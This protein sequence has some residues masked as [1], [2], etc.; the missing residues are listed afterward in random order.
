M[1]LIES[2]KRPLSRAVARLTISLISRRRL[3][4]VA[5][6]DHVLYRIDA[7][8]VGTAGGKNVG[9]RKNAALGFH[10][11]ANDLAR[12]AGDGA[13]EISDDDAVGRQFSLR[14]LKK[15]AGRQM[16]RHG[17]RVIGV[18]Q[19]NIVLIGSAG[20]KQPSVLGVETKIFSVADVEMTLRHLD[21]FRINLDNVHL[22]GR[23]FF[24]QLLRDRAAAEPDNEDLLRIGSEGESQ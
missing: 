12:G 18:D 6:D 22:Q 4:F 19:D 5:I 13:D 10:K 15:L 14:Q 16:E 3:S 9:L 1:S 20:Q 7:D 23:K 11:S 17:I 8:V 21:H 24:L 2:G